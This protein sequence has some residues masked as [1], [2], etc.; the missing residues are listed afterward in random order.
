MHCLIFPPKQGESNCLEF[1]CNFLQT[2]RKQVYSNWSEKFTILL[3][4]CL[5][6]TRSQML[7]N[8]NQ[9]FWG[10]LRQIILTLLHYSKNIAVEGRYSVD[11]AFETALLQTHSNRIDVLQQN[12]LFDIF[13]VR[14][15]AIIFMCKG[16][17]NCCMECVLIV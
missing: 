6:Q 5:N 9:A 14:P 16:R 7:L 1:N 11:A 12:S 3:K 13:S 10:K 2:P 4:Y 15:Y 17:Y 8:S